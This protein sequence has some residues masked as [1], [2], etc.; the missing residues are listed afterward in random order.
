MGRSL[1]ETRWQLQSAKNRFSQVVEDALEKGPQI[2]T[3]RGTDTAVVL[4]FDDYQKLLGRTAPEQAFTDFL[5]SI[6]RGDE[7]LSIERDRDP[8]RRIDL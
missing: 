5:L 8:G 6:P 2:V 1:R 3:R 4:S 7:G